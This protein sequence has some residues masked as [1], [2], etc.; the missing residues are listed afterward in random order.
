MQIIVQVKELVSSNV[1]AIVESAA[2]PAKMLRHLRKT[3]EE[4]DINLHGELTKLRRRHERTLAEAEALV[5]RSDD[6]SDK[7][8]IAMSKGREDLAR[9]ALLAREDGKL[10]AVEKRRDA[11]ALEAEIAEAED[12]LKL[13]V[14]KLAETNA[15]LKLA[16]AKQTAPAPAAKAGPLDSSTTRR[17]DHIATLER[18]IG[19]A[20][21]DVPALGTVSEADIEAEIAGMQRDDAV[22]AQLEQLKDEVSKE[23]KKPAKRKSV[24]RKKAG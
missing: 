11:S 13:L 24:P 8:R 4:T 7:A 22:D 1:S 19:F 6:W 3:I 18:R 21:D 14:K 9:A 23:A 5:R 17:L 15:Q 20:A 12:A 16:D 2:N 10:L